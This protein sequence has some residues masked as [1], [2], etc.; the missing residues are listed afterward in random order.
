MQF[1]QSPADFSTWSCSPANGLR[2]CLHPEP[3]FTAC[4]GFHKTFWSGKGAGNSCKSCL[5]AELS[6]GRGREPTCW[7]RPARQRSPHS[8]TCPSPAV[9]AAP[10]NH[11][12]MRGRED[13]TQFATRLAVQSLA[14]FLL[15]IWCRL[16]EGALSPCL[17]YLGPRASCLCVS[18]PHWALCVAG[19][20]PHVELAS[21]G[22][23][24]RESGWCGVA[25]SRLEPSFLAV[26]SMPCT[27]SSLG[28]QKPGTDSVC[29][30]VLPEKGAEVLAPVITKLS[31]KSSCS[32]IISFLCYYKELRS[33][34]WIGGNSIEPFK[35]NSDR[36]RDMI[37]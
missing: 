15:P 20:A 25:L 35:I 7:S 21:G 33:Y 36:K 8:A 4:D 17:G 3:S 16:M 13:E 28:A 5:R 2:T 26:P 10:Y 22:A 19:R 23:T 32:D 31:E 27:T 24:R 18:R 37:A 6:C 9:S 30:G 12:D 1:K 11:K 14:A 34:Y 29:L